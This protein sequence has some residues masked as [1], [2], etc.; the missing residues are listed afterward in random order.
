ML[1]NTKKSILNLSNLSFIVF[2]YTAEATVSRYTPSIKYM[3]L[4]LNQS[5]CGSS[6]DTLD[7]KYQLVTLIKNCRL[8]KL[9]MIRRA[10]LSEARESHNFTIPSSIGLN[11]YPVSFTTT[12]YWNWFNVL[13]VTSKMPRLNIYPKHNFIEIKHLLYSDMYPLHYTKLSILKM[14]SSIFIWICS[15]SSEIFHV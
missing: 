4:D 14:I 6:V 2:P 1:E 13:S 15:H 10:D 7:H 9:R 12:N 8:P 5:P 3:H 11:T